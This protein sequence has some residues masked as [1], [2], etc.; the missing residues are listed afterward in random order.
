MLAQNEF[1]YT[2]PFSGPGIPDVLRALFFGESQPF[3]IGTQNLG[4]FTSSLPTAP[5]ELEIPDA[6][7]ALAVNAVRTSPRVCCYVSSSVLQIHSVLIDHINPATADG[8]RI[9][10]FSVTTLHNAYKSNM[11]ILANLRI[12]ALGTYHALMHE[13]CMTAS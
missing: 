11:I 9:S 13:I 10:E 5:H 3:K 12:T 8:D 6:M 1:L 4:T 7:L 2:R